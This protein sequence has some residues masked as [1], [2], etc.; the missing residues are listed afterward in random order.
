MLSRIS[1]PQP[2]FKKPANPRFSGPGSRSITPEIEEMLDRG[3]SVQFLQPFYPQHDV[4][5]IKTKIH[6]SNE[7]ASNLIRDRAFQGV[8]SQQIQGELHQRFPETP[9]KSQGR[10]SSIAETFFRENNRDLLK[11]V[12]EERR[13]AFETL[14]DYHQ[15]RQVLIP[16]MPAETPQPSGASN[17]SKTSEALTSTGYN[18]SNY[19]PSNPGSATTNSSIAPSSTALST[20]ASTN[21]IFET[22][23]RRVRRQKTHTIPKDTK[24]Y[25]LS[26]FQTMRKN[27]QITPNSDLIRS[28]NQVAPNEFKILDYEIR[29]MS[30]LMSANFTKDGVLRVDP[31]SASEKTAQKNR[32]KA[33][34]AG[35]PH[36]TSAEYRIQLAKEQTGNPNATAS[37]YKPKKA[38]LKSLRSSSSKTSNIGQD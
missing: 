9:I 11:Q 2:T 16:Y 20:A 25:F 7:D 8:T 34:V 17:I 24:N 38:R 33:R 36:A 12:E 4:S 14:N 13:Q 31:R 35:N 1:S 19:A 30:N 23:G 21:S 5:D 15:K 6:R 3:A 28:I 27:N 32:S 18:S 29:A 10:I 37:D 22:K 26:N